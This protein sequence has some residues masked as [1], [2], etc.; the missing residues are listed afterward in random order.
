MIGANFVEYNDKKFLD[1]AFTGKNTDFGD[2]WYQDVGFQ[3]VITMTVFII[4]PLIDFLTEFIELSIHRWYAKKFVYHNE[5]VGKKDDS[6]D[7]LKFI[8]LYAGPEYGFYSQFASTTLLVFVTLML[9]P[10]LPLLYPLAFFSIIVQYF[11]DKYL[12]TKF[13]RLPP[14]YSEKLTL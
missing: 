2:M 9:G 7:F 14:K 1:K 4:N 10:I 5:V 11:F 13:Y 6:K 3:F 8:D 12:L